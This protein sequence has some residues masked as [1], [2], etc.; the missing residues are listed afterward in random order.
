MERNL[1]VVVLFHHRIKILRHDGL[2][3][4]QIDLL[5]L[6]NQL[7]QASGEGLPR[8]WRR[9]GAAALSCSFWFLG[10]K[11]SPPVTIG[12]PGVPA[13][14]GLPS[15]GAWMVAAAVLFPAST[16]VSSST[17]VVVAVESTNCDSR[18]SS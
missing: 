6:H 4:D 9:Q 13:V 10:D 18:S 14:D 15:W 16:V 12:V 2:E 11:G 1:S 8:S 17:V 7:P 3:L 5:P